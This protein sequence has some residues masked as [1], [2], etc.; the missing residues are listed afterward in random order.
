[1]SDLI[2]RQKAIEAIKGCKYT[3]RFFPSY[4]VGI[5]KAQP[6]V[7]I[8]PVRHGHWIMYPFSL[9]FDITCLEDD[10]VCSN[11][12][13]QVELIALSMAKLYKFCPYCGAKM[14]EVDHETD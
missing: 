3:D 9:E 14:D 7:E 12:K 8:E 4:A 2:S 11:C 10:V 13:K 6:A 1:M 5:I